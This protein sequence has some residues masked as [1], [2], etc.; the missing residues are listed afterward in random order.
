MNNDIEQQEFGWD[1]MSD[2][3]KFRDAV[4]SICGAKLEVVGKGIV[5][6]RQCDK[7]W[8]IEYE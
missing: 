2:G 3:N 4:C 7:K 5:Y 1:G 8:V 6:C